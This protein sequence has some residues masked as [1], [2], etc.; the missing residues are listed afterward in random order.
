MNQMVIDLRAAAA[1]ARAFADT[2]ISTEL[3][4]SFY[5]MARRWEAEA[6]Q[7]DRERARDWG[8]SSR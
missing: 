4:Q 1:S 2:A 5:A 8:T 6:D 7:R 3:R